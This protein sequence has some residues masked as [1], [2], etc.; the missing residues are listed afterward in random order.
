LKAPVAE[1]P[2]LYLT[3]APNEKRTRLLGFERIE[4]SLDG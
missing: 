3:D 4:Q 1:V 2:Q